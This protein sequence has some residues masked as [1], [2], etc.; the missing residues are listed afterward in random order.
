[1]NESNMNCEDYRKAIAEDPTEAFGGGAAHANACSSCRSFRNELR[2]LD[3][4]IAAALAIA[5]PELRMPDLP[6]PGGRDNV[7]DFPSRRRLTVPV[8]FGIAAGFA[9]AAYLG[10]QLLIPEPAQLTLAEQVIAHLDHEEGSRVVS[11]VAVSERTLDSVVSKSVAELRPGIGLITYARSCVVNNKVIPHLV[12][13]GEHG[14][15]TL[16]LMPDEHIDGP[17]SL[18]GK[19]ING[20][21]LPMGDGS[22]AIV[23]D[24]DERIDEI[25]IRVID[26]VKWAT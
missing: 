14:P 2:A 7:A 23:G 12:I 4:R 24:R 9:L 10:L 13:Q 8:W 21:I 1:M 15:V 25:S 3:Q 5:V 6:K 17:V 26:S 19:A 18:E 11:S 16:L 20:V 22:I